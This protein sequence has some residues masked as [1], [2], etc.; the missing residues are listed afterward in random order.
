MSTE[1]L[2]ALI[3]KSV[4][5]EDACLEILDKLPTNQIWDLELCLVAAS[6]G[7][8]K[9]VQIAYDNNHDKFPFKRV[10]EEA[11]KNNQLS[12]VKWADGLNYHCDGWLAQNSVP[13]YEKE[14]TSA[15]ASKNSE[16]ITL[17]EENKC[18]GSDVPQ[19]AI[20]ESEDDKANRVIKEVTDKI[21]EVDEYKKF[22]RGVMKLTS[23]FTNK[24]C[25]LSDSECIS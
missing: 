15:V 11:V 7:Y 13:L 4:V 24:D 1:S 14:F 23:L 25:I 3:C 12:V 21:L 16:I 9:V 10:C 17:L 2:S 22:M 18:L 20:S 5:S 6:K 8:L 19:N